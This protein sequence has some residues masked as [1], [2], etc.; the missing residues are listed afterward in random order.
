MKKEYL[1]RHRE[2]ATIMKQAFPKH[3]NK[4][5]RET[6]NESTNATYGTTDVQTQLEFFINL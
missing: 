6:N 2:N 3:L 5:S 1:R 4:E